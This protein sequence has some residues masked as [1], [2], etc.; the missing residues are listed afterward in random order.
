MFE[1]LSKTLGLLNKMSRGS[2]GLKFQMLCW[3]VCFEC[4][5]HLDQSMEAKP[6]L[7]ALLLCCNPQNMRRMKF[8]NV[9]HLYLQQV[10]LQMLSYWTINRD[11]SPIEGNIIRVD[12][13]LK[14][15]HREL[16]YEFIEFYLQVT[17]FVGALLKGCLSK[18]EYWNRCQVY[19]S[20]LAL[21]AGT[22]RMLVWSNIEA[23]SLIRSFAW[24][25]ELIWVNKV[26]DDITNN[27]FFFLMKWCFVKLTRIDNIS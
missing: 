26:I 24:R 18:F 22:I 11:P 27:H 25:F 15:L 19:R 14:S 20:S 5:L 4:S 2:K 8:K 21:S 7:L 6:N 16:E 3:E 13:G 17:M 12:L 1:C 10:F 9:W 23:Q